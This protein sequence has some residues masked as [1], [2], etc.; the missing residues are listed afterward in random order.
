VLAKLLS[1]ENMNIV[2]VWY[3]LGGP[4]LRGLRGI[5]WWRG[6]SKYSVQL[7][8]GASKV[9]FRDYGESGEWGDCARLVMIVLNCDYKEALEWLGEEMPSFREDPDW[10]NSQLWKRGM[11]WT[12]DEYFGFRYGSPDRPRI[13]Q[14]IVLRNYYSGLSAICL[15]DEFRAARILDGRE[16]WAFVRLGRHLA[17]GEVTLKQQIRDFVCYSIPGAYDVR[18]ARKAS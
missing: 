18:E 9:Q 7:F 6:G 12:L 17:A 10:A 4:K 3:R 13:S 15:R 11:L 14:W 8:P 16:A 1:G 5:A 2:E